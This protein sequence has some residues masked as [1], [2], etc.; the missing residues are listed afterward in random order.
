MER[1]KEK[2]RKK[3]KRGTH[4]GPEMKT[5]NLRHPI[6]SLSIVLMSETDQGV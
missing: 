5:S 2:E 4:S 1:G 3:R 6:N